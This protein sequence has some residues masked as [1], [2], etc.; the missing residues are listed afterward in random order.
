MIIFFSS[1]F[2]VSLFRVEGDGIIHSPFTSVSIETLN[3]MIDHFEERDLKD[4]EKS[5]L[6]TKLFA[7]LYVGEHEHGLYAMPSLVDEKT[8]IISP[9]S[10]GPL[11]LEGPPNLIGDTDNSEI[12]LSGIKDSKG[13]SGS[14]GQDPYDIPNDWEPGT[15]EKE[16]V[17]LFGFYHK[18]PSQS[19]I[20]LSPA[21]TSVQITSTNSHSYPS[22]PKTWPPY[23]PDLYPPPSDVTSNTVPL[24]GSPEHDHHS[25][26]KP[27]KSKDYDEDILAEGLEALKSVNVTFFNSKRG[28]QFIKESI[29]F[30]NVQIGSIEQK[31]QKIIIGLLIFLIVI[32]YKM[33]NS[34]IHFNNYYGSYRMSSNSV[35]SNGSQTGNI[36]VTALP[37][38]LENGHIKVGN[39]CF[40]PCH[41]LG[42]GCEGTFV[43]K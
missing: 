11:L 33:L 6:G 32:G 40:D 30:L 38:E 18:V 42:K 39:I 31:E 37:V 10:N 23:M 20:K 24:I 7:T 14:E 4:L 5:K 21:H 27:T 41:I 15:M 34:N 28:F 25:H 12:S 3:N 29:K 35:G 2:L 19:T 13:S 1:F 22:S 9:A 16:S 8:L 43:Y 17:L 26:Q 36:E